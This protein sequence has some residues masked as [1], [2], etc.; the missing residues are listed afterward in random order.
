MY[1]V[2]REDHAFLSTDLPLLM[3]LGR[4]AEGVLRARRA[5]TA[6]PESA[7]EGRL[8]LDH[9]QRVHIEAVLKRTGGVIEGAD[10]AARLL[11]LHPSTLRKRMAK[12]GVRRRPI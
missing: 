8:E 12:L 4:V 6:R 10:G 3:R 11:G 9:V 5:L 2:S 7:G 1:L